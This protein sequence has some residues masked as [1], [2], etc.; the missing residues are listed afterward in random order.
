MMP[1][2]NYGRMGFFTV[3]LMAGKVR[4]ITKDTE[5]HPL[6][7]MSVQKIYS[8]PAAAEIF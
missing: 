8:N 7:S 2:N 1:F 4:A 6:A 5:I 3:E